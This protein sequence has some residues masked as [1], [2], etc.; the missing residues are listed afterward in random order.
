[1]RIEEITRELQ[2]QADEAMTGPGP[3]MTQLRALRTQRRRRRVSAGA[4]LATLLVVGGGAWLTSAPDPAGGRPPAPADTPSS[5]PPASHRATSS[6]GTDWRAVDCAPKQLG[7]CTLP[8]SLSFHGTTY[9]DRVGGA[10]PVLHRTQVNRELS[11]SLAGTRP[12]LLLVGAT[13]A[14]PGSRLEVSI[15]SAPVLRVPG[16]RLTA[17]PVPPRQRDAEVV[18]RETG[19]PADGEVLRIEGYAAGG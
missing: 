16:G 8:T 7:G 14:G 15:G 13:G 17:V 10:V 11:L 2:A 1:M 3:D 18:V 12:R 5:A 4:A 19:R 6:A 9:V